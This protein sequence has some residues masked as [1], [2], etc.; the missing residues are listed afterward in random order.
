MASKKDIEL[1]QSKFKEWRTDWNKFSNDVLRIKLDPQQQEILESIQNNR[2]VSVCSGTAR[3]K[4]FLAATASLCFLYLTPYWDDQG[5]FHS[6]TVINTGPTDRQVKNIMMREIKS[7]YSGSILPKLTAF[8]F[9]SGRVVADGIKF[10]M[11]NSLKGKK[12]YANIEKWFLNAFKADNNN[13]EAWSGIHNTNILIAVT[14]A[15]GIVPLIYDGIEGCLQGNSK[16]L[17]VHNP[18]STNGEAYTSMK[19][20]QYNSFRLSSLT[21]PNVILGQQ[22]RDGKI[23]ESEYKNLAY[24]GQVDWEWLNE[25]VN[26]PGWTLRIREN[27]V[28]K[29]KHDFNFNGNYYRPSDVCKI[30]ILG[31]HPESSEDTLIPLSWIEAAQQR[32]IDTTKP[33]LKGIRGVDVSGMGSDTSV[34]ADRF[35]WYLDEIRVPVTT[36][37]NTMHMELTGHIKTD[38]DLFESIMIDCIGEGAAIFS[39]LKELGSKNVYNFKN[40]YGAKGLKDKTEARTFL[41]MRA[42]T[43]WA[44]RD[45]LDPRYDSL[46]CLPPDD[47]LKAQLTEI[48]YKIRSDG[49]IQ[50]EDKDEIKKR[51]GVSPD[52]ADALAQTFAPVARLIDK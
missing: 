8:G 37:P 30:K 13:T 21:S 18:N 43:H 41:N 45:W 2:R 50:I 31:E 17:L 22:L 44:M 52:K 24:P 34:F 28:D 11:P 3:G 6:S 27:E 12:E 15:S 33:E 14:E 20:P 16:L 48:K 40:S 35:D 29:S 23:T 36:D 5:I 49:I 47:E 39:R 38:L 26:K 10:D 25:K 32:W 46:A 42:Y 9:N 7:R 4:D 51:L 19:D 1:I